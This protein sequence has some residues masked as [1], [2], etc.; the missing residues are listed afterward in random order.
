M[1]DAATDNAL[2]QAAALLQRDPNAAA[3]RASAIVSERPNDG[4]AR[5]LLATALRRSGENRAA[6]EHLE[7]LLEIAPP[8]PLVHAERAFALAALGRSADAMHALE[9]A[10]ALKRDLHGVWRVLGDELLRAG[11]AAAADEAYARHVGATSKDPA[12]MKAAAALASNDL[13]VAER[14]LKEFLKRHPTDVAAIR[15]LAEVAVRIGRLDDS[16][17][18]L[19]RCLELAPSFAAARH[20]YAT[21]L[22]RQ[23]RMPEALAEVAKLLKSDPENPGYKILRAANLGRIGEYVEAISL[24]EEVVRRIPDQAKLWMS[25]GHALKTVGRTQECIEN[26]EKSLS[27]LPSLGEAWWSLA[28]LKTYRFTAVQIAEMSRQ[29]ARA[30]IT[31]EDRYHLHFALGKALEDQRE[32]SSSFEHYATGAALRRREIPYDADENHHAMRRAK[33]LY[34]RDFFGAREGYGDSSAAPIFI[35]GLPRA[36]ST[37]LEQILSTHSMVEGTMELPDIIAIARRLGH[38]KGKG[39]GA[40]YPQSVAALSTDEA[41]AL[42]AEY[43]ERTRIQRKTDKPF[44]IDKMPNNFAHVGLIRLILPNAKLIDARR[45]PLGCCFSA[46][47]QHFARGQ[48]FSYDLSDLGRYYRDYVELMAHFDEAAPG[49]VCRIFYE[50]MVADAEGETRRLLAY[51]GL[52]FEEACLSFYENDRPV[53]TASSEQVRRPIF[54]EGTDQWRNYDTWLG[55]LKTALGNVL[56]KYPEIPPFYSA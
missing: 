55:P 54:S 27:L 1:A 13:P 26:Y 19:Q 23:N 17:V 24:Y 7:T 5:F 34:T 29:L 4:E 47:K 12:L 11:D 49:V 37:L 8:S 14:S 32:F 6:L 33:A 51:C 39:D 46:F 52:P 16:A 9:D 42:G 3:E 20:N 56:D 44:F 18:L 22:G 31:P 38:K 41:R 25:Y 50:R 2:I 28:N 35:V 21:L 10:L 30:D 53:R 15:M 48:S 36:G 43:L 45:H 40:R